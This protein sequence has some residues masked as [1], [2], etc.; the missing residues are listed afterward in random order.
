MTRVFSTY[1]AQYI[2]GHLTLIKA[3]CNVS[4]GTDLFTANFVHWIWQQFHITIGFASR[5]NWIKT[6]DSMARFWHEI[7]KHGIQSLVAI[8]SQR[9]YWVILEQCY[10]KINTPVR[11][12]QWES[13]KSNEKSSRWHTNS[14][15]IKFIMSVRTSHLFHFLGQKP[16]QCVR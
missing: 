10:T 11:M 14:P 3:E 6:I 2:V 4:N 12:M 16:R 13:A 15:K 8:R 1:V 9:L 7:R 5:C